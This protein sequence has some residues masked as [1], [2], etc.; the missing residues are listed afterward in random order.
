MKVLRKRWSF[1]RSL[2]SQLVFCK[3]NREAGF[4]LL[5]GVA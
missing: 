3:K 1:A 5:P 4:S 2:S